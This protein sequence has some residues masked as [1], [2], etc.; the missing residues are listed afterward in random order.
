M[1]FHAFMYVTIGRRHE[2]RDRY[3]KTLE[4]FAEHVIPRFR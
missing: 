4:L 1:D 3:L 2:R